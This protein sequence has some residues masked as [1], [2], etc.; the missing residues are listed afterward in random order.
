[1]PRVAATL[2]Q[3]HATHLRIGPWPILI[4]AASKGRRVGFG[5]RGVK[6]AAID[7]HE[8]IATKEGTRHAARLGD[9]LTALAHHGLQALAAQGL[10]SPTDPRIAQPV[11]RLTG[12]Q[13]TELATSFCHTWHWF[14]RLHNAIA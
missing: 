6:D 11:L 14:T 9:Q 2:G 5:I 4:A 12:M 7:G 1:P 3:E 8:P 13:I 10:A